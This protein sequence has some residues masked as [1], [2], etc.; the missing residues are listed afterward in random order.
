MSFLYEK[1]FVVNKERD[2]SCVVFITGTIESSCVA[3]YL[4]L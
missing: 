2:L 4:L 3:N 1:Y